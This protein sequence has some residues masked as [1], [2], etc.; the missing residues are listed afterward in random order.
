MEARGDMTSGTLLY[1]SLPYSFEIALSLNQEFTILPGAADQHTP[2]T[3]LSV[4]YQRSE[5]SG[6]CLQEE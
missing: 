1:N 6:S 3:L 5:I 2:E 4:L